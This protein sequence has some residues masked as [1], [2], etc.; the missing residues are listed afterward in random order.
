MSVKDF[1]ELLGERLS[2]RLEESEHKTLLKEI[3]DWYKE[4][5]SKQVKSKLLERA[6]L[7]LQGLSEDVE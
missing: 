7:I 1:Y 2:L 6:T 3:L 4:G 5:G